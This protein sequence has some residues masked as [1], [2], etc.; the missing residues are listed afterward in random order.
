MLAKSANRLNGAKRFN[1]RRLDSSAKG[2]S[3]E[4]RIPSLCVCVCVRGVC[5]RGVCA[6]VCVCAWCVCACG[7]CVCVC[8][9]VRVCVRVVCVRACVCA[10]GVCVCVWCVCACGVCVCVCVRGVCVCDCKN[11]YQAW[12]TLVATYAASFEG[13]Q[14]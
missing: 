2:N 10:C 7:A 12:Y 6:C 13:E 3:R 14:D 11:E 1:E 4:K 9:C 8:V 5:V